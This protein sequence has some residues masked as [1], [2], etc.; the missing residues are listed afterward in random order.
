M[1]FGV[2]LFPVVACLLAACGRVDANL[3]SVPEQ[4]RQ[5]P[6]STPAVDPQPDVKS[7]VAGNL[8]GVF[9]GT[10]SNVRVGAPRRDGMHWQAC[11]SAIVPGVTGTPM[12]TTLLLTIEGGKVGTRTRTTAEHWC[13]K[14]QLEPI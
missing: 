7:I 3:T 12:S 11:V 6:S 13:A 5:P 1:R 2:I 9:V 8:A 4:F 14:E 10:P